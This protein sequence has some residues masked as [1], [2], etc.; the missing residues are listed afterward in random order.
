MTLQRLARELEETARQTAALVDSI[1]TALDILAD[2][3]LD[4][5][6]ARRR[7][8]DMIVSAL[9]GQDRIEQRCHNLALAVR[10]FDLLPPGASPALYD[11]IWSSLTLDELRQPQQHRA[12]P[13]GDMLDTELF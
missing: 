7:A 13:Q 11:E 2:R 8:A 12:G 3:G 5:D 10:R 6:A 4:P 1:G 9:Q